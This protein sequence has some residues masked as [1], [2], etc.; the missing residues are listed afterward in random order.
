MK[1]KNQTP[2]EIWF[3]IKPTV[4]H[5]R[6]F[7]CKAHMLDKT[8]N[9]DKLDPKSI[10]CIFVGYSSSSKAY[11]LWNPTSRKI[12]SSR[13]VKFLE[14]IYLGEVVAEENDTVLFEPFFENSE[15]NIKIINPERENGENQP[16]VDNDDLSEAFPSSFTNNSNDNKNQPREDNDGSRESSPSNS[17]SD[18]SDN[19]NQHVDTMDIHKIDPASNSDNYG[20]NFNNEDQKISDVTPCTSI[21]FPGR[22]KIERT[23]ARGRPRKIFNEK[24]QLHESSSLTYKENPNPSVEKALAGPYAEE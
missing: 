13:D 7:G 5:L 19:E 21:R 22:P 10:A 3:G 24:L 20:N 9:K 1:L 16:S 18:L 11:R 17:T 8:P 23:G 12:L 4:T 2:Y 15:T 14:D 6:S